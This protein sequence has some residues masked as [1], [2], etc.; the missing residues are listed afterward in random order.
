MLLVRWHI[1]ECKWNRY[2]VNNFGKIDEKFT[3]PVRNLDKYT[4]HWN[5]VLIKSVLCDEMFGHSNLGLR[6]NDGSGL[7]EI[8]PPL[9]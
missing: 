9:V 6:L 1:Q 5:V 8:N 7:I 4:L 3:W 2:N